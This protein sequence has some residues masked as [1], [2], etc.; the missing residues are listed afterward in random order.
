MFKLKPWPTK[1]RN[2]PVH[3]SFMGTH[4]TIAGG[5]CL[6]LLFGAALAHEGHDHPDNGLDMDN[7]VQIRVE[8]GQ[9]IIESNGIPNHVPGR[10]PNRN[11]PNTIKEQ[12]YRY[13][14]PADPRPAERTTRLGMHP[15]GIAV[16]GVVFDPA[17]NEWWKRDRSTGWQYD[18]TKIQGKLGLDSSNA[19]VQPDGAYHY[20][21]LPVGLIEHLQGGEKKQV[22]VGYAADGFPIYNNLGPADPKDPESDVVELKSSYRVKSGTR[23]G[24]DDG[25]GGKYDGTF[26]QDYEYAKGTGD[27][28]ECNGRFAV[29]AEYPEGTYQYVLTSEYPFVPRQFRGTPDESFMR[30]GREGR[31]PGQGPGGPDRGPR[32]RRPPPP[33]APDRPARQD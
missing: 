9:R 6:M 33:G 16:N 2:D 11:N 14:M 20:H 12:K 29:T 19:H 22:L 13:T 32:D 4:A 27:L 30:R 10:F 26:V 3:S 24:G 25:P 21:G 7:R 8:G 5:V 17:A 15:F 1:P 23:P 18:P 31:G 28:D